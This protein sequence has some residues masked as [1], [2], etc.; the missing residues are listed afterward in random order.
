MW[1]CD[2]GRT[3]ASSVE[4]P[5]PL[6]LE[7]KRPL[8]PP[9]PAFSNDPRVR[10]D[11]SYEPVASG[12][13]I[14]VPSMVTDSVT[15]LDTETGEPAWT[16]FADGP[17]R[18]APVAWD[19]KVYFVSDDGWL[20]CVSA[21][22]GRLVWKF[23]PLAPDRRAYR[24]LGNERLVSRWPARGGPVLA[25]A[26]LYFAAGIWPSEGVF[27]CA[28][29]ART[30]RPIWVNKDGGFL[31]D[32]VLDHGDRRDGALAPQ[33]YLAVI[34]GKLVVP[35]GRALPAFFDLKTGRMEPYTTG[36]G[37]R[38]ALAKGCWYVCGTE[39][40]LLQSGDV[41]AL[42]RQTPPAGPASKDGD[43][44]SLDDFARHMQISKE[45][46]ERWI[47]DA[48]LD[49]VQ[50]GG[51]RF[52]RVRNNDWITYLSW[53]TYE[54]SEP[55]R[56]G[57]RHA[58][59]TRL[60]LE[61]D[62][63]NA[64]ELGVFR[65]P[66]VTS[67][68][69]YYSCP[70]TVLAP[71]IEDEDRRPPKSAEYTQIAACRLASPSQ[72]GAVYQGG[73]GGRLV[74]WPVARLQRAWSL[75]SPWK[76]HIKAGKRLYAGGPGVVAAVDIP[77]AGSE[78]KTS[79]QT[80]IEGTPTRMLAADGKLFVITREGSLYCF[81]SRNVEPKIHA[82]ASAAP[83][84]SSDGWAVKAKHILK[85]TG[86][87]EGYCLALGLGTGR[88]VEELARQSQLHVIALDADAGKIDTA[89][90]KLN[91]MGLY[92]SRVHF[93][94][95]DLAS[96][97]LPPF[98]ASLVVCEDLANNRSEKDGI[99]LDR[100]FACLRPYGGV[101]CLALPDDDHAA[102]ARHVQEAKIAG[103]KLARAE[104]FT[105]LSRAGALPGSADWAHEGGD[106]AY[107]FASKDVLARPPFGILWFG[108][109]LDRIIPALEGPPP[110][111][112]GGRMVLRV[113]NELHAVDIYTGR[114]LWKWGM[115]GPGEWV[116]APSGVYLLAGRVCLRLDPATGRQVQEIP[117]PAKGASQEGLAWQQVRI[118]GDYL[119]GTAGKRLLCLDW[120]SGDL[121][122][123][124]RSERDGFAFAVGAG[125]VFCI[126]Y[127]LPAHQRG[128]DPKT[129][130]G[131]IAALDVASGKPLWQ[132]TVATPAE[133]AARKSQPSFS[134]FLSPQLAFA[135]AS[136]VLVYT[137][138]RSTAAAYQGTTGR[139]L[140]SR[141]IPCKGPPDSFT[142]YHPPI[143]LSDVLV[144]HGG[145]MIDLRTG[146]APAKPLW[147]GANADLRGCG[148]A[149][150]S[151]CMITVRDGH[152]SYYDLERRSHVYFRGIRS[153]CTNSLIPADGILSAPNFARGCTCNYPLSL[154]FALV[155]MPEVA[156]WRPVR[157]ENR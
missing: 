147:K 72:W 155:T 50:R 37:G 148:R 117:V 143:V 57:E 22:E 11:L 15:A 2:A 54:K 33:G 42:T 111:I 131:T 79:W 129:E 43:L 21:A 8:P 118:W 76:V 124:R 77:S 7:W 70:K 13:R 51:Q 89:R 151:P 64:K 17:V 152:A 114:H 87:S 12:K 78:A 23:S 125:K 9:R 92:G 27:V 19:G 85:R 41:F 39:Q 150:G 34:G 105:F 67:D 63:A 49:T 100:L 130:E 113:G 45:T 46:A 136:D 91:A 48:R 96:L 59:N 71:R 93:V 82:G 104:G 115:V 140:W 98:L 74:E 121:R 101:A 69:I 3:G 144:S 137:R 40:F 30:G 6:H 61:I 132:C 109:S 31:R 116:A 95:G 36:W 120:R 35:N 110:R 28:V 134:P 156:A 99:P 112:A 18:F 60:R 65:E 75:A 56:P 90:R 102:F 24:L 122:W 4:L 80:Q 86:A 88:L 119:I 58:L 38:V 47:R 73:W 145:E 126:D 16:F 20:Y 53:W 29:D 139:L 149:L 52:L 157:N 14:Y 68:A 106:A 103:A 123:E 84:G 146:K 1:R 62:P 154:S 5:G 44:V 107:T 135:E 81:G 32:A 128:E 55:M 66:V 127:W 153:G 142:G 94:P 83:G 10:F 26:T 25:D 141:E 133:Q 138:N 108:G 97:R